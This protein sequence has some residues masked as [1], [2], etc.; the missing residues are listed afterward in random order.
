MRSACSTGEPSPL[1][2]I[3]VLT[4]VPPFNPFLD[5]QQYTRRILRSERVGIL[6]I[7]GGVPRNWAQQIGPYVDVVN[8]RLGMNLTPPRFQFGVRIC[9]EP[10]HW[11]GLSGCSYSEG[12]SWGK[13]VP[14]N[15]G[16]RFAEIHADATVVWPVLTKAVFEQMDAE[17]P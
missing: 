1:D 6:T 2:P 7:G 16:G 4:A 8:R 5:L 9:P 15:Q 11:G 12:I 17:R 13:F 14:S 3:D 10:V